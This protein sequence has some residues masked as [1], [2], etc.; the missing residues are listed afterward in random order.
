MGLFGKKEPQQEPPRVGKPVLKDDDGWRAC[1]QYGDMMFDAGDIPYAVDFWTEAVD[2]FDGSD[3]AFGKMCANIADRVVDCCRRESGS[4]VVC[5]VHLVARIETEIEI[6]LP[7]IAAEGSM[8]QRVFDGLVSKMAS[9]GTAERTVILFTSA[10]FCQIGYIGSVCDIREVPVRCGD[11]LRGA[12]A[13][14][15][16]IDSAG[17]GG[18][19]MDPRSAHRSVMLYREYFSDL[20]DCVETVLSGRGQDEIDRAVSYWTEHRRERTKYLSDAL[21]EKSRYAS[22]PTKFGKKGHGRSCY[23]LLADFAEEYFSEPSL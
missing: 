21:G 15:A 9:G 11:V 18:R 3:K 17:K 14:D 5:P 12:D 13:A 2:R 7:E 19:G 23:A 4:G 6:K 1:V 22:S 8:T 20:R 10:C 16:A